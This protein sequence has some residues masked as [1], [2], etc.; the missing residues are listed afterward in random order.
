MRQ[1]NRRKLAKNSRAL[2]NFHLSHPDKLLYPGV[3][4][5]K[6]DL[7]NYY[8]TVA[9]WIL[10]YILKR[11]LT[12]LRCPNGQKKKCFYQRHLTTATQDLYAVT[13]PDKTDKSEPYLYIKDKSG[14]MALIQL[15][16]L[17]IH[18]WASQIDK[19]EKPD[20]ITF[21]LDPG[22]QVEWKSVIETAFLVKD[23]LQK[24]N[25]KSFVKTTG[26]KGL[27]VVVPIK[28]LYSWDKI[29]VFSHAFV[30]Y[31]SIQNPQL[32]VANMS[33]TKRRG[34][35]FVDY[36]RNQRGASSIAPYSTRIKENATVATPLAWEELN[37]RIKSDSFTVKN[38]PQRLA[39]LK[40]DPWTD[41]YQLK[42]KL[43]LPMV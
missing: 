9:N 31:L 35:I 32:I 40:H 14:L 18:P 26:S 41:F 43:S 24:L 33:K 2:I 27:H 30:K 16:V 3:N 12:L 25:L 1:L 38:L 11:P 21:D 7:A 34:K 13:L 42:Q 8:N 22:L 15:G 37:A 5:T 4:L 39:Q 19:I 28:R 23:H 29:K 20:F 17:E 6:L 10:P 36:L